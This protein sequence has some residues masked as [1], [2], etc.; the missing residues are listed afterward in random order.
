MAAVAA[1]VPQFWSTRS[2]LQLHWETHGGEDQHPGAAGAA[3]RVPRGGRA[4]NYAI[5][6]KRLSSAEKRRSSIEARYDAFEPMAQAALDSE[7]AKQ[8]A[9]AGGFG[10]WTVHPLNEEE[11]DRSPLRLRGGSLIEEQYNALDSPLACHRTSSLLDVARR[12]DGAGAAALEK[13]EGLLLAANE[14]PSS[15]GSSSSGSSKARRCRVVSIGGDAPSSQRRSSLAERYDAMEPLA[16]AVLDAN[17]ARETSLTQL[18][19]INGESP[20]PERHGRAD[21]DSIDQEYDALE[22]LSRGGGRPGKEPLSSAD[23]EAGQEPALTLPG[24]VEEARHLNRHCCAYPAGTATQRATL[25]DCGRDCRRPALSTLASPDSL[26]K[27]LSVKR[28]ERQGARLGPRTADA[29]AFAD[30]LEAVA[31]ECC[32]IPLAKLLDALAKAL[33]SR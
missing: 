9:S 18:H 14:L 17:L 28:E 12:A 30:P 26:A 21:T 2:S 33:S 1:E 27:E 13:Q 7:R 3:I 6:E 16:M 32:L 24:S 19:V 15:P 8:R 10:A 31:A 23:K 29:Q 22:A 4:I 25:E 5:G 11:E 20:D